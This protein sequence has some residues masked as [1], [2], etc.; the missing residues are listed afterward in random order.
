MGWVT[1][2][3]SILREVV[4]SWNDLREHRERTRWWLHRGDGR[5]RDLCLPT[6]TRDRNIDGAS[7]T[8]LRH[9]RGRESLIQYA[10]AGGPLPLLG[11]EADAHFGERF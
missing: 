6:Q 1:T 8:H 9:E 10:K 11:F 2:S 7:R 3:R 4:A 5:R